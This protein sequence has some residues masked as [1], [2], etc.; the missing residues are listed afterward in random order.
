[1]N[2]SRY[3]FEIAPII[4]PLALMSLFPCGTVVRR[5]D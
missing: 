4:M 1:M 5:P 3:Y 2:E